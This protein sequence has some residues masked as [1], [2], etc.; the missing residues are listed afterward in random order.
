[1]Q[2]N[3]L[4]WWWYKSILNNSMRK[5]KQHKL[6]QGK[7]ITINLIWYISK[8]GYMTWTL[9]GGKFLGFRKLFRQMKMTRKDSI[10]ISIMVVCGERKTYI[11]LK[12]SC[13]WYWEHFSKIKC[14]RYSLQKVICR[15]SV[16][17]TCKVVS[18]FSW[19]SNIMQLIPIPHRGLRPQAPHALGLNPPSQVF[20]GY[21]WLPDSRPRQLKRMYF[22]DYI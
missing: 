2:N 7:I 8:Y 5:W 16:Q 14:I 4:K 12:H 15:I 20:I 10:H 1:M 6:N 21:H 18:S 22:K 3:I 19:W 11:L 13:T 17:F 9:P